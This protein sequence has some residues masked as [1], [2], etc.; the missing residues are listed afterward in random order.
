MNILLIFPK[1]PVEQA[2]FCPLGILYIASVLKEKNSVRVI[3]DH[4][5]RNNLSTLLNKISQFNPDMIGVSCNTLQVKETYSLADAIKVKFEGVKIVV[6]GPHP[7][8]APEEMLSQS[9]SIDFCVI[10]EGEQTILELVDCISNGGD[11]ANVA[12]IAFR[13][14]ETIVRTKP[15][16]LIHNLDSIPFPAYELVDPTQYYSYPVMAC[17]PSRG[18][19]FSCIFC[20]N[21]VFGKTYRQRSAEN[22][23]SEV[24]TVINKYQ[25][26][27]IGFHSDIFNLDPE[28]VMLLCDEL[29]KRG[30]NKRTK[31]YCEARV[32][33]KLLSWE[34]L[35]K[36][37]QAGCGLI[38]FGIESGNQ[39]ILNNI[40]KAITLDE[41]W[42]AIELTKRVGIKTRAL[43]MI[44]NLG[45]N[46]ETVFDSITLA[47]KLSCDSTQFSICTPYPGS[48]FY[49]IAQENNWIETKDY[50]L[51]TERNPTIHIEDLSAA[52]L[53]AL[54]NVA[55]FV[56]L[57]KGNDLDIY[58]SALLS[59]KVDRSRKIS[60]LSKVID[61]LVH[62]KYPLK[63]LFYLARYILYKSK[64]RFEYNY[65]GESDAKGSANH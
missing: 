31:W 59:E 11:L 8:I 33:K 56:M 47:R 45:E 49:N 57:I 3:D 10:G 26:K 58:S 41:V 52:Q 13:K 42:R 60:G 36:M 54:K 28:F 64:E 40:K 25:C 29:I 35:E 32:N 19:P 12:G 24:E 4:L 20:S 9:Q 15:R 34:L 17:L 30:V 43:L 21:P 46:V 6:G 16:G 62:A 27:G 1:V 63:T 7:T 39:R 22:I 65:S 61:R 44:G 2:D 55:D 5:E 53:G 14:E 23:V 18:C 50:S 51:Y 48:V 38:S 37:K